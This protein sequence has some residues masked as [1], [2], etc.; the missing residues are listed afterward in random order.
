VRTPKPVVIRAPRGLSGELL[1]APSEYRIT[2]APRAMLVVEQLRAPAASVET[3]SATLTRA[4]RAS[5]RPASGQWES[6]GLA[7]SVTAP[8][9]QP[10]F[11]EIGALESLVVRAALGA[12]PLTRLPSLTVDE[13]AVTVL[14]GRVE[15]RDIRYDGAHD[16]Q[17]AV[18]IAHLDL[19]RVVALEQQQGIEASGLLDGRLPV[20]LSARGV[21]IADGQLHAR[22]PG[23]VIRYQGTE[24]VRE[25][26][27]SNPN[28]K[29]VLDAL[30]NYHYDKLDVGVDYAEN[31]ELALRLALAGR[32]PGWNKGQPINLN[33]NISE[34]IPTLLRSLR[35]ADDISI[36]L[37]KRLKE[38]SRPRR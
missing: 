19:A 14:G 32:N 28:L 16:S 35:L 30:G 6:G 25:M 11:A 13:A 18:D 10:Q 12:G 38:R 29:L 7:V 22:P 3:L 24:G 15:A 36:E 8:A 23:G 27:A 1:I 17:F 9:I 4:A 37:E 5:F 20:T 33:V 26:A 31:G 21:R 34:N 2:I